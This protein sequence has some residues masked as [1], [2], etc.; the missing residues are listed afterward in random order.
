L[1]LDLEDHVAFDRAVGVESAGKRD[2]I[3]DGRLRVPA[4]R[5]SG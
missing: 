1:P 3:K 4:T 2:M 5:P